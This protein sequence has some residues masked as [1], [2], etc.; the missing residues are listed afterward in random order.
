M[1][2]IAFVAP[3]LDQAIATLRATLPAQIAAFNTEHD[4]ITLAE[5]AEYVFGAMDPL[6][7]TSGPIIEVAAVNGA[8][9]KAALDYA[10][11]DHSPTVSVVVWHEGDRGELSPTYRMS[12]GLARCVIEALTRPG[13]FGPSVE[14]I[15]DPGGV[16][17]RTDALPAEL[18]DDSREFQKWQVPVLITFQLETVERY[19]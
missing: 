18:T 9:G 13:A 17:W 11:F 5:P 15:D 12:L 14:V 16:S 4:D 3:I 1:P 19:V 2:S 10:D 7:L 8:T 6:I